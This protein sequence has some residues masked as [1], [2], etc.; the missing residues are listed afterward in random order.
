MELLAKLSKAINHPDKLKRYLGVFMRSVPYRLRLTKLIPKSFYLQHAPDRYVTHL[1]TYNERNEHKIYQPRERSRWS[2]SSD[3]S[4]YYFL[5]LAS[6]QLIK[7]RIIGDVAEL[8]VYKG[9]SAYFLAKLARCLGTKA[10]FFDTFDGFNERDLVG[11]D[12]MADAGSFSDTS[13][14]SVRKFVG[15]ENVQ[16][17]CGYFPQSL[18]QIQEDPHFCLV[19]IDCDLYAPFKDALEYFYPRLVEGGML[20]M[21]DYASYT[22]QGVET[23]VDAFFE[24]KPER[25]ILIPDK[26]GTAVIRKAFGT[27][28]KSSAFSPDPTRHT[29]NIFQA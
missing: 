22:W 19:H 13:L 18:A 21:H 23:A 17:I 10:Y 16:Y 7:E 8:G 9:S 1:A 24:D 2:D 20:V 5:S 11:R 26:S 4:R 12:N 27:V 28:Q 25:P 15:E 29:D 14:A 6:D 3:M